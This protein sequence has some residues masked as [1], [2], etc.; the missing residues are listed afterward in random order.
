MRCHASEGQKALGKCHALVSSD[1][2]NVIKSSVF[3]KAYPSNLRGSLPEGNKDHLLNRARSDLAK[4][5]LH[6]ESL[7]ECIGE[8]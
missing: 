4:Q 2:G 8:L 6:V 7:N 5:E 1:Q 3:R